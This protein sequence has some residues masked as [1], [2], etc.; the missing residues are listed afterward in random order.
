MTSSA[1]ASLTAPLK[2]PSS[3][4]LVTLEDKSSMGSR[5]FFT[6]SLFRQWLG[7]P[8]IAASA[9]SLTRLFTAEAKLH[10]L[11]PRGGSLKL[12]FFYYTKT[13]EILSKLNHFQKSTDYLQLFGGRELSQCHYT[14]KDTVL[15][16]TQL[17]LSNLVF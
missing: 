1:Q 7:F 11:P 4:L 3:S 17:P 14:H 12:F 13:K 5:D 15:N 10:L 6:F 16:H 8:E 2:F 9:S